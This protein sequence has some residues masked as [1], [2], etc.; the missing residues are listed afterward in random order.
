M[1]FFFLQDNVNTMTFFQSLANVNPKGIGATISLNISYNNSG[2]GGNK[3]HLVIKYNDVEYAKIT[4]S[5]GNSNAATITY[6][7]N[8]SGNRSSFN[9]TW[10][11]FD[12][13]IYLPSNI[14][15]NGDFKIEFIP[16]GSSSNV[17]TDDFKI[18]AATMYACPV[19]ISGTVYNDNNG[20]T[21]N[22]NGNGF[23]GATVHLYNEAG[24]TLI[25]STT[26]DA[27]GN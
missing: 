2:S 13:N 23:Q 26:T 25:M 16:T 22:A 19:V 27:N 1:V 21:D 18:T 17:S 24:T 9:Q 4:T 8:A 20:T 7:N 6:S 5:D 15:N 12:W 3:S 10:T 11:L 14:P